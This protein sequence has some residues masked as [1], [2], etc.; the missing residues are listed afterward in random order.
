MLCS[1]CQ[2]G[3]FIL[4]GRALICANC[5]T[6]VLMLYKKQLDTLSLVKGG[7]EDSVTRVYSHKDVDIILKKREK[8]GR[9]S[10]LEKYLWGDRR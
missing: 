7:K 9:K 5:N 8:R 1:N 4:S 6:G 2:S 3:H 10:K